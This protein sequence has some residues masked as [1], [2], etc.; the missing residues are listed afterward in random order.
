EVE[1][2]A[3]EQELRE[4]LKAQKPKSEPTFDAKELWQ[5]QPRATA[6]YAALR[7]RQLCAILLD[8]QQFRLRHLTAKL[9]SHKMLL[10]QCAEYARTHG[11]FASAMLV[12]QTIVPRS[13]S[14]EVN[15]LHACI[16][17]IT[18]TGLQDLNRFTATIERMEAWQ[19]METS[20]Q[21]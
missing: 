5:A 1:M 14:G 21:C 20:Q 9:A 4:K 13:V 12:Q 15:K 7:P 8:D 16:S 19:A 2:G 17:K 6:I 18:P 3:I 11:H 10:E